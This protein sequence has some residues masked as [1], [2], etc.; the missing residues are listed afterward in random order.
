MEGQAID[1]SSD[2][3]VT[4]L[5]LIFRT[6]K[7]LRLE[8]SEEEGSSRLPELAPHQ[9]VVSKYNNLKVEIAVM[10]ENLLST[11]LMVPAVNPDL[12]Q[13]GRLFTHLDA[14]LAQ[15]LILV[16][17]PPVLEKHRWSVPGS[18]HLIFQSAGSHSMGVTTIP[19]AF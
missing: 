10:N 14:G 17:A 1:T 16:T 4:D 3:F 13:R 9:R 11:K 15:K 6:R 18:R 2:I 8:K 7:C 19:L 12:V 5:P